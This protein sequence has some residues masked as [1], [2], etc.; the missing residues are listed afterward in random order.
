[1]KM[2]DISNLNAAFAQHLVNEGVIN[3]EQAVLAL[4]QQRHLTQPIGRLA[5]EKSYLTM[6]QVFRILQEQADSQMRFGEMAITLGYLDNAQLD[7]LLEL[8]AERRP[9]LC[10]VL[11]GMGLARKGVLQKER[12]AFVRSMESALV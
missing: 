6:K 9:G 5:L 8:Q 4:E 10:D 7:E 12:K 2:L 1:M 11:F 3:E